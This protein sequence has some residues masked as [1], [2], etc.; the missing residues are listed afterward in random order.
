MNYLSDILMY[1]EIRS[2]SDLF[3]AQYNNFSG[4]P[5]DEKEIGRL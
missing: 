1:N 5:F 4:Y 3:K 2:L